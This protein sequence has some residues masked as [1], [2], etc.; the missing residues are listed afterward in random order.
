MTPF[1]CW[2]MARVLADQPLDGHVAAMSDPWRVIVERLANLAPEAR[3]DAF[4]AIVG[5]RDDADEIVKAVAGQ[6]PMGP[7]PPVD[8]APSGSDWPPLR[9]DALPPVDP[10][11]VDV[12]PDPAARLVI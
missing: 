6:D 7:A 1:D 2:L 9:L 4:A 5:I 10:F 8:S 3:G 12:F 11:P